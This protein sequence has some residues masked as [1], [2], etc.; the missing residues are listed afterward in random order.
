MDSWREQEARNEAGFRDRN[1]WIQRTNA[2]M[3]ANGGGFGF[4]CECG[5]ASCETPITLTIAEYEAV[6]SYATRFAVAPDHENPEAEF[7]VG[8]HA[9]FTVVEKIDSPA[10]RIVRETDPRRTPRGNR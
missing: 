8:E 7:V 9:L 3:V 5:D 4:V 6:R 10:R 1:E 2:Q